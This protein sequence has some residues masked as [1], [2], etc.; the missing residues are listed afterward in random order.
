MPTAA[1]DPLDELLSLPEAAA[2]L[3]M[4]EGDV[5]ELLQD[6][7]LRGTKVGGRW[8]TTAAA[9]EALAEHLDEDEDDD[10]AEDDDQDDDQD[11]GEDEDPPVPR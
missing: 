6:G 3:D 11:D 8:V 5:R 4:S 7:V 10:Q 2:E 9:V 1:H